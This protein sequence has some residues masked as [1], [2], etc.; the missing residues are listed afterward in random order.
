MS[1][2][3][4]TVND[5]DEEGNKENQ[6]ET[7]SGNRIKHWKLFTSASDEVPHHPPHHHPHYHRG[8]VV[9]AHFSAGAVSS[10]DRRV[11][12]PYGSSPLLKPGRDGSLRDVE[13][14]LA[15]SPN[16]MESNS[17]SK[18]RKTSQRSSGHSSNGTPGG[19]GGLGHGTP[20]YGGPGH[21]M[22]GYAGH[23]LGTPG[24]GATYTPP[25]R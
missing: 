13:P 24:C 1:L 21:G 19:L 12:I 5:G 8:V 9:P 18:S 25:H 23:S 20:G 14:L 3:S 2:L 4:S 10:P 15:A 6:T 11:P 16:I 7:G 22:P 17:N